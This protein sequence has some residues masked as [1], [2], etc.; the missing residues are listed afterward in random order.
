MGRRAEVHAD[1]IGR[2]R[3]APAGAAQAQ[4]EVEVL[5]VGEDRLVEPARLLPCRAPVGAGCARRASQQR[6]LAGGPRPRP[7]PCR[8]GKPPSTA[9]AASPVAVDQGAR[10][11][12]ASA[13]R[14]SRDLAPRAMG[15]SSRSKPGRTSTSLLSSTTISPEPA[16]TPPLQACCEAVV[17]GLGGVAPSAGQS[18]RHALGRVVGRAVVDHDHAVIERLGS[19]VAQAAVGQLVTVVRHDH[20]VDGGRHA[21]IVLSARGSPASVA[22]AGSRGLAKRASCAGRIPSSPSL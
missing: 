9:S 3:R 6:A 21:L 22:S 14:P 2:Q 10:P 20:D 11:A 12:A 13:R 16:A 7:S 17:V 15:L 8:R 18:A 5:H 1:R 19:K 4:R